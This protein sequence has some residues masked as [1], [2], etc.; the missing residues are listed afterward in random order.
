MVA[1]GHLLIL[2]FVLFGF[3]SRTVTYREDAF[4]PVSI[5]QLS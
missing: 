2:S 4:V 1:V 3:G 5:V